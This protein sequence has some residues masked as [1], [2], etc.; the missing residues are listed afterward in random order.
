VI[1]TVLARALSGLVCVSAAAAIASVPG[2]PDERL[3]GA[4][5]VVLDLATGGELTSGHR[6]WLDT[7][8]QPGSIAKIAT[9][10]AALRE[11]TITADARVACSREL[12]LAGGRSAACSHPPLARPLNV[13]DA[14]AHSCN[15][16]VASVARRMPRG[17]LSAGHVALGLPPVPSG[18]DLVAAAL[19]MGSA[20]IA[21]RRLPEVVRR[22]IAGPAPV[23]EGLARA[24]DAGTAAA[25]REA[26]IEAFAK[27]G[28][29]RMRD[30]RSL[31]LVVALWPRVRP[32]RAVVVMVPAGSGADAAQLGAMLAQRSSAGSSAPPTEEGLFV[33]R[34]GTL[35]ADGRGYHVSEIPLED[36]VAQVVAG[37]ALRSTPVAAREAVA[38]AAR[39]FAWANR[40]RHRAEGFDLCTLT[41]CQVIR[42]EYP[43]AR[44]AALRTRG[45]V[46]LDNGRV[47][48]VFYSAACGGTIDEVGAIA[49][50]IAPGLVRAWMRARPD[51]ARV[52][53]PTWTSTLAVRDLD[54]VFKD[55]GWRGRLRNLRIEGDSAGR[56]RRVHLEG[57]S[58]SPIPVNDFRRLVGQ[59]L[60]WQLVKSTAF[61][62]TRTSA[63]FEL[64]GRGSGHGVGLCLFGA[65]ALADRGVDRTAILSAYFEGLAVGRL[66]REAEDVR[67]SSNDSRI[68]PAAAAVAP[69]PPSPRL[70]PV[71]VDLRVPET[72]SRNAGEI[73]SIVTRSVRDLART[74]AVDVPTRVPIVM[75]PT[76]ASYRRA[77]GREWWTSA[78]TV[79]RDGAATI[80]TVPPDVL[81]R[82]GQLESTL[83]HELVHLLADER[84]RHRPLWYREALAIRESGE[85]LDPLE[86]TCPSDDELTRPESPTALSRAYRRALA[87]LAREQ[88]TRAG[89]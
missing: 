36:Y 66:E 79:W 60:G 84:L 7:P 4:G 18:D 48:P 53:E 17:A 75:H 56:A 64:R 46:L 83:R 25:F 27:T 34:I 16:F 32:T 68:T 33:P 2:V 35:R 61:V 12:R 30:G 69:P 71:V 87:C 73:R 52:D 11:G 13:V 26:G 76:A 9:L 45:L 37:E 70:T 57:L 43:E 23:A 44:D 10:T 78:A 49:L 14:L 82:H 54:R 22:A 77:T 21:P 28:T 74:L 62:S 63:G 81:R 5:Y 58:P 67:E 85:R 31:G 38:I 40:G 1:G 47:S 59:R 89:F 8:V 65:S 19:G 72:A 41:H 24:A 42:P 6:D 20:R 3:Q 15:T 29:S 39:S 88:A 51:P 50:P 80:H 55:A 86:G